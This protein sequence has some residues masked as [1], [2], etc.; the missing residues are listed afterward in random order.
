MKKFVLGHCS[1]FLSWLGTMG[2]ANDIPV[3][4]RKRVTRSTIRD[5]VWKRLHKSTEE[6]RERNVIDSH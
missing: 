5:T 4:I 1:A 2:E 3:Q 6:F